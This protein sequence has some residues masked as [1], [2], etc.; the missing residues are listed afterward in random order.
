M[1]LIHQEIADSVVTADSLYALFNHYI[2]YEGASNFIF[3]ASIVQK[4]FNLSNNNWKVLTLPIN[5]VENE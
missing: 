5:D 2:T 4:C 3:A 1:F